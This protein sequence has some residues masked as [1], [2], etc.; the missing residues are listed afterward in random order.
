MLF[1]C[2]LST[3]VRILDAVSVAWTTQD[4]RAE[5]EGDTGADVVGHFLRYHFRV[6]G[7]PVPL[8]L[9]GCVEPSNAIQDDGLDFDAGGAVLIPNTLDP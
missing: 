5:S 2:L 9:V 6:Y 1:G 8:V 3:G 4:L 7:T